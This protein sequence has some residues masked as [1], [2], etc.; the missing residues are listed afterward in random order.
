MSER[1]TRVDKTEARQGKS[2]LGVRYVLIG[3]LLPLI[4]LGG[5]FIFMQINKSQP[6]NNGGAAG[7]TTQPVNE[8]QGGG[9]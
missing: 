8:S 6:K 5:V 1:P 3:V 7:A 2:G 4:V 9:R